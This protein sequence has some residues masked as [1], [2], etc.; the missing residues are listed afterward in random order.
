MNK[1]M[2]RNHIYY[3]LEQ[4]EKRYPEV[5][6][7]GSTLQYDDVASEF[8]PFFMMLKKFREEMRESDRPVNQLAKH[9]AT[10]NQII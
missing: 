2:E 7:N 1:I 8:D 6:E 5:S 9:K 4:L 3:V 10:I